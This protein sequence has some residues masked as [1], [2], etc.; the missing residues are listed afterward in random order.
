MKGDLESMNSTI[1]D[2]EIHPLGEYDLED[3]FWQEIEGLIDKEIAE[4]QIVAAEIEFLDP[5]RHA[6]VLRVWRRAKG[7]S[8][9]DV[10]EELRSLVTRDS[11]GKLLCQVIQGS[12]SGGR[13]DENG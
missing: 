1:P 8:H 3:A 12:R 10:I 11:D 7:D 2:Y 13:G 4:N 6:A 5:H 9:G